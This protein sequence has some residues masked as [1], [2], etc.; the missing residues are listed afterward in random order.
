MPKQRSL[1]E[2]KD[3]HPLILRD[4]GDNWGKDPSTD[5][6]AVAGFLAKFGDSIFRGAGLT[7]LMDRNLTDKIRISKFL[8]TNDENLAFRQTIAF[9]DT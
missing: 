9:T 7:G 5:E 6:G 3:N 2:G 8:L 1:H 4:V